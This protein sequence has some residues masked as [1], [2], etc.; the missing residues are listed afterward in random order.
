[1]RDQNLLF[2]AFAASLLFMPQSQAQTSAP[3]L[4]QGWRLSRREESHGQCL[5]Q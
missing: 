4:P 5:A 3:R 2:I 1:M